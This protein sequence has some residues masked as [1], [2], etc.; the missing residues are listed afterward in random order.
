STGTFIESEKPIYETKATIIDVNG[1]EKRIATATYQSS[2]S[3]TDVN[4]SAIVA[5]AERKTTITLQRNY[6][7]SI[8]VLPSSLSIASDINELGITI[9]FSSNSGKVTP[10]QPA[11]LTALN[12]QNEPMGTFRISSDKSN[13]EG[14]ANYVYS[15]FP[16]TAYSGIIL[17]I[18]SSTTETTN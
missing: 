9:N 18:G 13:S 4:I 11:T 3:V 16:D 1:V 15:L 5:G 6:A 8:S 14:F 17:F 7:E 12:D 10:G 2:L